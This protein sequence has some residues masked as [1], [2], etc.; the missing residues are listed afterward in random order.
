MRETNS[1]TLSPCLS[2]GF[3]C[4]SNIIRDISMTRWTQ[5]FIRLMQ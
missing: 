3:Y 4:L 1:M 5:K 2:A